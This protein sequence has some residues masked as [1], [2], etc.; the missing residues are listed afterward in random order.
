MVKACH[1]HLSPKLNVDVGVIL[2]KIN[3]EVMATFNDYAVHKKYDTYFGDT[4][5]LICANA[6]GIN[7]IVSNGSHKGC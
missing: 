2:D 7:I 5:P 3:L 1:T 6:L 4:I